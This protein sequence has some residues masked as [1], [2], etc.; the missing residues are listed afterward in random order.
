MESSSGR[1]PRS[2]RNRPCD[3]C[4]SRK[5]A[6]KLLAQP[7]CELCA[8]K[9]RQCTFVEAPG[10]RRRGTISTVASSVDDTTAG[11]VSIEAGLSEPGESQPFNLTTDLTS[12]GAEAELES[13]FQDFE[14]EHSLFGEALDLQHGLL[15]Q[16]N[17]LSMAGTGVPTPQSAIT[18]GTTRNST[19]HPRTQ[20]PFVQPAR[21]Q[22]ANELLASELRYVGPSGG[23][24]P[25]L[26]AHRSYDVNDSSLSQYTALTYHRMGSIKADDLISGPPAVFTKPSHGLRS[27]LSTDAKDPLKEAFH[28]RLREPVVAGLVG[29]FLRF[30]H[31]F[32][33]ILSLK[34]ISPCESITDMP[35]CLLSAIC[36]TAMPFVPY[37]DELCVEA[38][39]LPSAEDLFVMA[40]QATNR[41][42]ASPSVITLQ[43]LLLLI[44]RH[45]DR[46]T[47]SQDPSMWA[48][49]CQM[50]AISQILGLNAEPSSWTAIPVWERR[51]RKRLWWAVWVTERWTS[52]GEGMAS[53]LPPEG[54]S[55]QPLVTDDLTDDDDAH[56]DTSHHF[57]YLVALT[58]ILCD[59]VSQYFTMQASTRSTED[60]PN[61]LE[62]ARVFRARLRIW[63]QSLPEWVQDDW[64]RDRGWL[65]DSATPGLNGSASLR[66]AFLTVQL[67]IFRALLRPISMSLLHTPGSSPTL[68]DSSILSATPEFV[69]ATIQGAVAGLRDLVGFVSRMTTA[70]WDAFW[71]GCKSYIPCIPVLVRSNPILILNPR[72]PPQ[73]RPRLH[74]PHALLPHHLQVQEAVERLADAH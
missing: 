4:R 30:V 42:L 33:P 12:F 6:C 29:L 46:D 59:I 8:A 39:H 9:G 22:S 35:V 7:P 61:A 70:D 51:L 47:Q 53:H 32:F 60:V 44:N 48:Q 26:I 28:Q 74:P 41:D 14:N 24:D 31:P 62:A 43:A 34:Q 69:S 17:P 21:G 3:L 64:Q 49:C 54:S 38:S 50:V 10:P 20:S 66:L 65:D 16:Q 18:P 23:L 45:N 67:A 2:R 15:H 37:D 63:Q 25:F 58:H 5:V 27:S 68:L 52:F 1:K 36:A 19:T 72:V 55:V 71:P 11:D 13:F 40:T 56:L 73:L 57:V